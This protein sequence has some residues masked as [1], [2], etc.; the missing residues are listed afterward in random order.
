MCADRVGFYECTC[1]AGYSG[2]DCDIA[3]KGSNV[4]VW[5]DDKDGSSAS[6]VWP[7]LVGLLS[8]AGLAGLVGLLSSAIGKFKYQRR[9]VQQKLNRGVEDAEMHG[10]SVVECNSKA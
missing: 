3:D 4:T 6:M 10:I 8:L 7:I 2:K 9:M 5:K 1:D